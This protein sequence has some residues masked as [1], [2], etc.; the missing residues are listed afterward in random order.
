[1]QASP[2]LICAALWLPRWASSA[3]KGADYVSALMLLTA[4][5]IYVP[6]LSASRSSGGDMIALAF[7]AMSLAT[8]AVLLVGSVVAILV[9]GR[10]GASRASSK[11]TLPG[12]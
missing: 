3:R 11:D 7:V 5:A 4:I 9:L 2:Y 12:H 6:V 8:A 10:R 1:M